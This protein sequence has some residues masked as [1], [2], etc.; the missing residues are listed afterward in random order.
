MGGSETFALCFTLS[1]TLKK[2]KKEHVILLYYNDDDKENMKER[3]FTN[4]KPPPKQFSTEP[5]SAEGRRG[6]KVEPEMTL[7]EGTCP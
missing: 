4:Q 7:H 5:R 3:R 2:K 1:C 6:D